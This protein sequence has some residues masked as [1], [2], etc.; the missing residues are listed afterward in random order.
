MARRIAD[1]RKDKK[2]SKDE[3]ESEIRLR[4]DM[5]IDTLKRA[6]EIR[7]DPDMET[8]MQIELKRQQKA[9]D[10]NRKVLGRKRRSKDAKDADESQ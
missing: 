4:A 1:I 8:A 5:G 7:Q 10:D 9:V 2:M 3:K 6:D